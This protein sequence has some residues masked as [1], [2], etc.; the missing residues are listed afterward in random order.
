M[1]AVP[2]VVNSGAALI[3]SPNGR[4]RAQVTY[5]LQG[6]CRRVQQ[7]GGA[8]ALAKL[9]QGEWQ[10]LFLDRQ[11]PISMLT[12]SGHDRKTFPQNPGSAA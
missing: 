12:S 8:D 3:A 5:R 11:L 2:V 6:R 9:E 4:L 10:V 7:A 1:S